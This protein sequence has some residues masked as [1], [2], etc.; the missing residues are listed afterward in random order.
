MDV[1]N[2]KSFLKYLN[3]KQQ[4]GRKVEWGRGRVRPTAQSESTH[5]QLDPFPREKNWASKVK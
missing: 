1:Q 5:S 4:H 3:R 2:T